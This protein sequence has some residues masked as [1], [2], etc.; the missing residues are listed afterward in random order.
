M[1]GHIRTKRRRRARAARR[2]FLVAGVLGALALAPFAVP[3]SRHAYGTPPGGPESPT[4]ASEETAISNASV[5]APIEARRAVFPYSVVPG[6][7]NSVEDLRR[8]MA[9]DAVV[10]DHYKDF[11]LSKAHVE[12]LTAPRFA[13]VSYRLGE[14]VY[15][16]R[17]ELVLPAGE[18]VITDGNTIARTRCG[19]QVASRPGLTSPSE[20]SANVLDTPVV[21]PPLP[22]VPLLMAAQRPWSGTSSGV[23]T[24]AGGAGGVS[25]GSGG[26]SGGGTGGFVG[27]GASGGPAGQSPETTTG[28]PCPSASTPCAGDGPPAL[29]PGEGHGGPDTGFVPPPSGFAP[30]S[31]RPPAGD[32]PPNDN[33]PPTGPPNHRP[34]VQGT[35]PG[36]S[37]VPPGDTPPDSGIDSP[38]LNPQAPTPVPEPGSI[39]LMLTGA[40]GFL[41]RRLMTRPRTDRAE[42]S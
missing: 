6:G 32:T 5:D 3:A 9:A 29:G 30:P 23:R 35:T 20:P 11:D 15:W 19:N 10:A 27:A 8:A 36:A 34:D 28:Q 7:V 12:R 25:S 41:V 18:R 2:R 37:F 31:D 22:S 14:H 17:R 1:P 39:V 33:D 38:P 40:G 13:H 42:R 4:A 16:T 26:L 24:D 21:A